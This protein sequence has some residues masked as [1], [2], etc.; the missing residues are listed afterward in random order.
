[1]CLLS[2]CNTTFARFLAHII[3]LKTQ[4]PDYAIKIMRLDNAGEFTSQTFNDYCLSSGITVE[5]RVAHVHT[6]NVFN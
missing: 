6:R 3:R 4:I 5:H 1:M 2:T